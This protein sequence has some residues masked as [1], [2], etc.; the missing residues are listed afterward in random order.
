MLQCCSCRNQ[1]LLGIGISLSRY[2]TGTGLIECKAGTVARS[3]WDGHKP[4]TAEDCCKATCYAVGWRNVDDASAKGPQCPAG[5]KARDIGDMT[6]GI[7]EAQ[8]CKSPECFDAKNTCPTG[9][10]KRDKDDVS[11]VIVRVFFF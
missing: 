9:T 4:A 1:K 7:T 10:Q 8:C 5:Q 2:Y 6:V 3:E 11:K